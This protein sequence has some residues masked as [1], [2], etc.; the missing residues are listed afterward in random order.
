MPDK[1]GGQL[2]RPADPKYWKRQI[3]DSTAGGEDNV[4]HSSTDLTSVIADS[5]SPTPMELELQQERVWWSGSTMVEVHKLELALKQEFHKTA[6]SIREQFKRQIDIEH[7]NQQQKFASLERSFS[8]MREDIDVF[9]ARQDVSN[10][11]RQ[12]SENLSQVESA[13]RMELD[14]MRCSSEDWQRQQAATRLQQSLQPSTASLREEMVALSNRLAKMEGQSLMGLVEATNRPA[15]ASLNALQ[16]STD[17]ALADERS[18]RMKEFEKLWDETSRVSQEIAVERLARMQVLASES[19]QEGTGAAMAVEVNMQLQAMRKAMELESASRAAQVRELKA[20]LERAGEE[21]WKAKVCDHLQ[22]SLSSSTTTEGLRFQRCVSEPWN[23]NAEVEMRLQEIRKALELESVSRAM[24]IQGLAMSMETE[25]VSRRAVS[26]KHQVAIDDI[27]ASLEEVEN[28]RVSL[29]ELALKMRPS[30]DESTADAMKAI[31]SPLPTLSD[32]DDAIDQAT[33]ETSMNVSSFGIADMRAET[34]EWSNKLTAAQ[35][36]L[37]E[38]LNSRVNMAVASIRGDLAAQAAELQ[39]DIAASQAELRRDFAKSRGELAGSPTSAVDRGRL[40]LQSDTVLASQLKEFASFIEILASGAGLLSDKISAES[41][42][43][44]QV[45]V[46]INARI[47]RVERRLAET[48]VGQEDCE[49]QQQE[50]QQQ[51]VKEEVLLHDSPQHAQPDEAVAGKANEQLPERSSHQPK[52][53]SNLPQRQ[54]SVND[55]LKESLEQLVIRVSNMLDKKADS[56][57][58]KRSLSVASA[59]GAQSPPLPRRST[60]PRSPSLTQR[61]TLPQSPFLPQRSTLPARASGS[62]P[63][64]PG[65]RA[66]RTEW[67]PEQHPALVRGLVAS[68]SVLM[69]PRQSN[70]PTNHLQSPQLAGALSQHAQSQGDLRAIPKAPGQPYPSVQGHAMYSPAFSVTGKSPLLTPRQTMGPV[71]AVVLNWR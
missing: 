47:S 50:Q 39:G 29:V 59:N 71:P 61:C 8:H 40:G 7:N 21:Q 17:A 2:Y 26:D 33:S 3:S 11:V 53:C 45:E 32:D 28:L 62:P 20:E 56:G 19:A 57:A 30:I 5:D 13:L 49:I 52:N 44:R 38:E 42:S 1:L 46:Q 36:E 16:A 25:R 10:P 60:L 27:R 12:I 51:Q 18:A 34:V 4:S 24:Q 43:R 6:A 14:D 15:G 22:D 58:R 31:T 35:L 69:T 41:K 48:G 70:R 54:S 64:M 63:P 67:V 66:M 9:K 37:R 23:S 65:G 68:A 55:G